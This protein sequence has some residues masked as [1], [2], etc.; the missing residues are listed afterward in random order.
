MTTGRASPMILEMRG[1][2]H[3]AG[4]VGPV[5]TDLPESPPALRPVPRERTFLGDSVTD[6]FAWLAEK[7]NPDAIAYLEA[8]NTWTGKAT[9]HL[10]DLRTTLFDEIRTRTQETDLSVPSRKGAYW[11]Y[12]RTVEGRQ[13][14][15]HCRVAVRPGEMDPPDGQTDGEEVLL[16]G[17]ELAEGRE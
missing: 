17:N 4:N 11:Y 13:Y 5:T 14:V 15:I 6:E 1:P 7:E 8:E 10:E 16:D 12:T 2:A 3:P 9:A